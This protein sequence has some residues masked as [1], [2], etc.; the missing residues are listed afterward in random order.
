MDK[1][2]ISQNVIVRKWFFKLLNNQFGWKN[3][4]IINSEF[5]VFRYLHQRR[6]AGS[7]HN[8]PSQASRRFVVG[9]TYQENHHASICSCRIGFGLHGYSDYTSKYNFVINMFPFPSFAELN[10]LNTK[11][12]RFNLSL[13]ACSIFTTTS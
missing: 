9:K 8:S 13:L 11:S 3:L 10:L 12:C 1:N 2:K 5:P 6:V 7:H 4:G